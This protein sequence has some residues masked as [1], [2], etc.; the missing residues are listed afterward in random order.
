[1]EILGIILIS[2]AIVFFGMALYLTAHTHKINHLVDAENIKKEKLKELLNREIELLK[3]RKEELEKESESGFS[4]YCDILEITYLAK[5]NEFDSKIKALKSEYEKFIEQLNFQCEKDKLE[6]FKAFEAY[7]DILDKDYFEKEK[8]YDNDIAKWLLEIQECKADLN[9]IQNTRAAA[10]EAQLR[11]E[12]I[13]LQA[14]FY[15][16][17]LTTIEQDTIALIEELKPRLPEPRVL[18]MLIWQTF[19]QKQMTTLC[20]NI[21]GPN[22][23]CG[24]YKI[25]NKK[26]GLCYIGQAVNIAD[27]WKQ[28]AKCSLGIDTPAQN[29]LYKAMIADGLTNFTFELLEK[30]SKTELNEK[31]KFYI[32]LYQSY[33]FGYNSNKG[34]N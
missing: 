21:L 32:N 4:S 29:K 25:T 17:H 26:S 6:A 7:C 15:S 31:E 9:K 2:A 3:Q 22:I 11:E 18:N 10:L 27:R 16:L 13:A 1:M 33:E 12:E 34:V 24:I 14:D 19:Y 5:E 23:I 8:E 30:C 20:N 28:H